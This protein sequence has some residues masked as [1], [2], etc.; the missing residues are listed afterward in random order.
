MRQNALVWVVVLS[1]MLFG[2]RLP[3]AC[4]QADSLGDWTTKAAGKGFADPIPPNKKL[5]FGGLNAAFSTGQF[6]NQGDDQLFA[7]YYVNRI[8]P[9]ITDPK[10]R[11]QREDIVTRLH[12][13]FNRLNK[14]PDS[15][16][17][18]K[19]ADITLDY[20][21]KIA[22]DGKWHPAVRESALLAI[23]EV[24]SPK[25][26]D[27]LMKLI[28]NKDLNPM[29]KVAAM[30]DLVH[31]AEQGV[32]AD[33][34]VA[35]PV[36]TLMAM[37]APIKRPNDGWRWMRGQAADV[38]AAVRSVGKSGEVPAALLNMMADEDLPLII[39]GKAAHAL[40]KLKFDG[41]LPDAALYTKTFAQF[42]SDAL[43]ENLPGDARRIWAV[44][45]D[46]LGGIDP[47]MQQDAVP[48][49]A[50][51]IHH[52]MD[53]LRKVAMKPKT[54][55]ADERVYPTEEELK[56]ALATARK[57]LDAAAKKTK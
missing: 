1:A 44:C 27:L 9:Y 15:P 21:S 54:G 29:F 50:R 41:K 47:L 31:L 18:D 20:M 37:A 43:A 26:V 33:D 48:K 52:A 23:G 46:F 10:F 16:V 4:A 12:S 51:D 11:G 42:G 25:T 24:K 53:E 28:K 30:A 57:T 34:A 19:L 22:T 5:T 2:P 32:L 7:D 40:G 49:E 3:S 13:D 6:E 55:T 14:F 35:E 39:R 36:V 38:L 56:P 8:F 17:R 45:N